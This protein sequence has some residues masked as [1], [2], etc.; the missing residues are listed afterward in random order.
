MIYSYKYK[1]KEWEVTQ[2]RSILALFLMI[3]SACTVLATDTPT[4]NRLRMRVTQH[5][6]PTID[7]N[8]HVLLG[9]PSIDSLNTKYGC[10]D[11]TLVDDHSTTYGRDL[12]TF[13]YSNNV[14]NEIVLS[15]YATKC[16]GSY[17]FLCPEY[18]PTLSDPGDYLISQELNHPHDVLG[19]IYSDNDSKKFWGVYNSFNYK[20][21][22][23]SG[24]VSDW[25]FHDQLNR[26]NDF[27]NWWSEDVPD[28]E[29]GI[30]DE[31]ST[32]NQLFLGTGYRFHGN[33]GLWQMTSEHNNTLAAWNYTRG[34]TKDDRRIIVLLYDITGFSSTHPDLAGVA[35][36]YLPLPSHDTDH[37]GHAVHGTKCLGAMAARVEDYNQNGVFDIYSSAGVAPDIQVVGLK[38]LNQFW[39]ARAALIANGDYNRVK[40]L[41]SS[42]TG[43]DCYEP[44]MQQM[45]ADGILPVMARGYN[46]PNINYGIYADSPNHLVVGDYMPDYSVRTF[47][48]GSN[49]HYNNGPA[50][51][52]SIN[53]PGYVWTTGFN[54]ATPLPGYTG[55]FSYDEP[56]LCFGTNTSIAT[57]QVAG[58]AALIYAMYP[59]MTPSEVR[60]QIISGA[61]HQQDI[62]DNSFPLVP[63][64]PPSNYGAGAV[65][66]MSS[67][68]LHGPFSR[69]F[70]FSG[71]LNNT[72]LIGKG[73]TLNNGNMTVENGTLRIEKDATVLFNNSSL[74]LGNNVTVLFEKGARL[75]LCPN[76][77]LVVGNNVTFR[78]E[79]ND[80]CPGLQI[81]GNNGQVI[82]FNNTVFINVPIEV[83]NTEA[84]FNGCTFTRSNLLHNNEPLSINYS[85]FEFSGLHAIQ[86]IP[87]SDDLC[88]IRNTEVSNSTLA[89]I[90]ITGYSKV[91]I[92]NNNI[93]H[94]LSGI[95]LYECSGGVVTDNE[96]SY[97]GNGI[98]LYHSN[99]D[100]T[101][102]NNITYN[103]SNSGHGDSRGGYGIDARHLT[104]WTL[105]G[106]NAYPIQIIHDNQREQILMQS[107]SIP[108]SMYFNKVYS[109]NHDKPYLRMWDDYIG[110]SRMI[111]IS[112]NNWSNDFIPTRDISPESAFTYLPMWEPGIPFQVLE[113]EAF[114]L[115]EEAMSAADNMD[116][117]VAE[118]KLKQIIAEYPETKVCIDAAK[119]LMILVEKYNQNYEALELY[120]TTYPTL[121]T[122]PTLIKMADYLANFCKMKSGDYPE[123][124][125]FFEDL[126]L[127]P[128]S[129]PDSLFAV[130]DAGYA[131][132]LMAQNSDKSSYIGDLKWLKPT[133]LSAYLSSRNALIN[134][135]L[136][137]ATQYSQ[138]TPEFPEGIRLSNYPN[139]FNPNTTINYYLPDP[140]DVV[141]EVFNVKGQRVKTLI[142]EYKETG[143]H[144]SVW[145]GTDQNGR[146]VSSGV[147]F[148]RLSIGTK[149]IVNKM[150]LMK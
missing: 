26:L 42:I 58:I 128:P 83:N 132:L 126:I 9:I 76:S 68:Y 34:K 137:V 94:N 47:F 70:V 111:N 140:S 50:Y 41:S 55:Q 59:W 122:D 93:H 65:N 8:G 49:A 89:G 63:N 51:K 98:L 72:S 20:Y 16:F 142:N 4:T 119:Q 66:A 43:M 104:S 30:M 23:P 88:W 56:I 97:N 91:K 102:H 87:D 36:P 11:Y 64:C 125:Q 32:Q 121:R 117:V 22:T 92:Q 73:F 79:D 136:S 35:L 116:Y 82:T 29:L 114:L 19:R 134:N 80:T 107:N 100:I 148:Y 21:R 129:L 150:L 130:I 75:D 62:I 124:I 105:I 67:L 17:D 146:L 139:P 48:Q 54:P 85:D 110:S 15:E 120:Y 45:I 90:Q 37:T 69:S 13:V 112:N 108:S 40:V 74:I 1:K 25:M 57:P 141:L 27:S 3:Y 144:S 12:I 81:F 118:Q 61:H 24:Y 7:S 60:N 143:S 53:A 28:L 138:E 113:D 101:G 103:Y 31:Y 99:A 96:I 33:I 52:A 149:S 86:T 115:F 95:E 71:E 44:E 123:A 2:I 127:N 109:S 6:N 135:E 5:I 46:I 147:Y 133:S 39:S 38:Y 14:I 78:T 77:S 18:T 145:N 131:Y 10:Q 106:Q 84:V